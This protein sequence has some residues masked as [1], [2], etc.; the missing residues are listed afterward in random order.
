MTRSHAEA[1]KTRME[2]GMTIPAAATNT[3]ESF[4]A[5]MRSEYA[6]HGELA[7]L[8]GHDPMAPKQ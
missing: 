8:T 2:A 1:F 3:P 6:R 7:R 5:F 4:A